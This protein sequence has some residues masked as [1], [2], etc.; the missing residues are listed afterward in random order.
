MPFRLDQGGFRAEVFRTGDSDHTLLLTINHVFADGWS[1]G[2]LRRDLARFYEAFVSGKAPRVEVCLYSI[3]TSR[4]GS[5]AWL[6]GPA[7]LKQLSYWDKQLRGAPEVLALPTDRPRLPRITH[8]G[9]VENISLSPSLIEKLTA[10]AAA[11]N[12]TLFMALLAGWYVLLYRYSGQEEIL[13]GAPIAN[14]NRPEQEGLIGLFMNM[15]VLRGDLSG[16]PSF[17]GLVS[18]VRTTTLEA[19]ANQEYPL[20]KLV[21]KLRPERDWSRTPFYQN[22]LSCRLLRRKLSTS[23]A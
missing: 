17:R 2:V 8:R 6:E 21:E 23:P 15:L 9:N 7:A 11:N 13:V 1:T 22:M 12:A 19:F 4:R 16:Q 20:E 14:R 10:L 5:E 3:R 18:R